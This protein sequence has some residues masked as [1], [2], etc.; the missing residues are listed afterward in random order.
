MNDE[1]N[2][3]LMLNS[4]FCFLFTY[5][6]MQERRTSKAQSTTANFL[7]Q[8]YLLMYKDGKCYVENSFAYAPEMTMDSGDKTK[9]ATA[10]L[11]VCGKF[12]LTAR[13]HEQTLV[14]HIFSLTHKNWSASFSA[15]VFVTKFE[16]I[17][18]CTRANKN[19]QLKIATGNAL[20]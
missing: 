10:N 4:Q 18:S 9:E 7:W 5:E 6:E 1:N 11:W 19:G 8:R 12:S 14:Y 15:N 13:A 2:F 3:P 16:Q 17:F 20:V